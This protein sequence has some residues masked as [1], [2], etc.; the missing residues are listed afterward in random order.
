MFKMLCLPLIL[1]PLSACGTP[2]TVFQTQ[3]VQI[4]VSEAVRMPCVPPAGLMSERAPGASIHNAVQ[5]Q[6]AYI[7]CS[8]DHDALI[9]ATEPE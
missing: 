1:W 2:R 3:T 4:R 7:A 6:N 8:A 5:W 9:A